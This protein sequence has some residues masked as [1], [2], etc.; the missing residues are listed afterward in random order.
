MERLRKRRSTNGAKGQMLDIAKQH[1][2]SGS[3]KILAKFF[4]SHAYRMAHKHLPD[5]GLMEPYIVI[6]AGAYRGT[7]SIAKV[8]PLV[9]LEYA[10]WVD[11]DAFA[12]KVLK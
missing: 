6:R 4:N 12:A 3:P 8:H 5:R 10:R 2:A 7:P 9:A 11:Y 1:R